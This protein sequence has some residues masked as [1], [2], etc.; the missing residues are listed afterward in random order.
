MKIVAIASTSLCLAWTT[1]AFTVPY[2]ITTGP[3]LLPKTKQS[4]TQ[5]WSNF[6]HHGVRRTMVA[7]EPERASSSS[8]NEKDFD[9]LKPQT[10]IMKPEELMK[11]MNRKEALNHEEHDY[12][13]NSHAFQFS[14][15]EEEIEVP[16]AMVG[17]MEVEEEVEV[18]V[19]VEE[20]L[21]APG[22][23]PMAESKAQAEES[24]LRRVARLNLI[25]RV[26]NRVLVSLFF[27]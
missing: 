20:E 13:R 6:N 1:A 4:Y 5:P 14:K 11:A 15:E 23:A 7:V 27:S 18:E 8:N 3:A 19:E 16:D 21:S 26:I 24:N 25:F 17:E 10:S 12:D 2:R 9:K 22:I